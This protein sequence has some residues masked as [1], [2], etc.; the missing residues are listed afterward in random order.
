MSMKAFNILT[1]AALLCA[2]CACEKGVD[3]SVPVPP[4]GGITIAAACNDMLPQTPLTRADDPTPKSAEEK[5][6]RTLHLFFFD[7]EG[8]FL[9]PTNS[10]TFSAYYRLEVPEGQPAA[11]SIS[12]NT[13]ENQKDLTGVQVYA[14]A[15]V[16]GNRFRTRWTP[17][18][19]IVHGDPQNPEREV[20][21]ERLQDLRDWLYRPTPRED[22]SLL[23]EPGMPMVGLTAGVSLSE[24][25]RTVQ[26]EMRALMA[27]VDV[28]VSLDANQT[29]HDRS[30]P[31]LEILSY[32]VR[33]MPYFVPF[34][35]P[36]EAAA[37]GILTEV[38]EIPDDNPD[39]TNDFIARERVVPYRG[40]ILHDQQ[41]AATFSYYTY[42]NV[43]RP[44]PEKYA[45]LK[46]EGYPAGVDPE[47]ESAIQRWKPTIADRNASSIVV[48][49]TYVTH[50]GLTYQ[51]DFNV[52][53]GR[54]TYDNFEVRRNRCYKNNITIRGLDYV[55]N[56]DEDV[57]TFDGRVN[58]VTDNPLYIAIVNERKLDAHWNVVPM[59]LY[60]LRREA[61][62][63]DLE[64]YVD[65]S[66]VD[67][68]TG[69]APDWIRMEM[70]DSLTMLRGKT[71]DDFITGGNFE[72]GTGARKYFYTDLV[73]GT[74]SANT[75][76]RVSGPEH[77]SR[78]RIYFYVDENASTRDRSAT[79]YITYNNK[80]G[81]RR[82]R[83][84]E[85]DQ[86]GLLP[87]RGTASDGSPIDCYI[88]Y[89]EE[90]VD[91]RDPL[92]KHLQDNVYY[93]G[94]P[95]AREGAHLAT[96]AVIGQSNL[97]G[98]WSPFNPCNVYNNGLQMTR[99]IFN[100]R[101]DQVASMN[102]MTTYPDGIPASAF[103][104]SYAK[105]RRNHDGTYE[106][107]WYMPGISEIETA[108]SIYYSTF[109]EFQNNYYW[110]A[111]AAKDPNRGITAREIES[112]SYAR[113]TMY[114]PPE[115]I[116]T[117]ETNT[118][119]WVQSGSKGTGDNYTGGG[120]KAK[121]G[122]HGEYRSGRAPKTTVFRIR[123]FRRA[124][125]VTVE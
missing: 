101:A 92:D 91:H 54:N 38:T 80:Q 123:A 93:D 15:N 36:A 44:D 84:L 63:V 57:Y 20:T 31:T 51:A 86:K 119:S 59:D 70:I 104:Y 48:K 96:N 113:A 77:R 5:R 87:V 66:L 65:V 94:L 122:N 42:E 71:G 58:V 69:S 14:V 73:S 107:N 3:D 67:P 7:A 19:D 39:G 103:H 55:R 4:P 28:S 34:T 43:Q 81:D 108:I 18:G 11:L 37:D 111:A 35:P 25:N 9:V 32:G 78:S 118:S 49:G 112:A 120:N 61:G 29:N 27:R 47:D 95:W 90:Y 12:E 17:E 102:T 110:S 105:N 56:S 16:F 109:E 6:I 46:A 114:F 76:V 121:G 52:Y 10:D 88:E 26:I 68:A 74:L 33:N 23:P 8:N 116:P 40:R 64:S 79:V 85:L 100:D 115:R 72:A 117:G 99:Y 83:T 2:L 41:T 89:Y 45:R 22:I 125:G 75:S 13:F 97:V 60:F 62:I 50:Q 82:D 124:E 21:V 106:E 98:T 24:S 1:C 53:M 30:L